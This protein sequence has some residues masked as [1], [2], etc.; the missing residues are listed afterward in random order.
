MKGSDITISRNDTAEKITVNGWI[1]DTHRIVYNATAT[2][3]KA[4]TTYFMR[5]HQPTPRRGASQNSVFKA[6]K[7]A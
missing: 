2:E 1:A 5:L 6:A 4:F 3:M 7:L